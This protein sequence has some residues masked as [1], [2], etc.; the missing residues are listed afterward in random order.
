MYIKPLYSCL[1]N[2]SKKK[3]K[4]IKMPNLQNFNLPV[5]DYYVNT[6]P[7]VYFIYYNNVH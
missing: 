5:Q 7:S 6:I 3:K 2:Y 1:S 4:T